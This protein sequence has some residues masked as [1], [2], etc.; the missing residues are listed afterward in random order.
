MAFDKAGAGLVGGVRAGSDG[1]FAQG[2]NALAQRKVHHR[3][4]GGLLL[5]LEA[6]VRTN[7]HGRGIGG[8]DGIAT[9][10]PGDHTLLLRTL[11]SD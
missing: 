6:D 3:F 1:D 8:V 10:Q 7:E 2:G 9:I 11:H 4:S 5:R